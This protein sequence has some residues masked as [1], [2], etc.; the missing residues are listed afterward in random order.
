MITGMV[1]YSGLAIRDV[2][3]N[4]PNDMVNANVPATRVARPIIGRSMNRRTSP[5]E[6]P[7]IDAAWRYRGRIL[8]NA[9][10]RVRTTNG[11]ATSV[12][13]NGINIH[14]ARKSS[15]GS[16]RATIKPKPRVTALVPRGNIKRE[17][18]PRLMGE[19]TWRDN[20]IA[21]GKP[22]V[23]ANTVVARA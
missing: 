1:G 22:I 11:K 12:W 8:R 3:P 10:V 23:N 5:G 4:S 21:A 15:G 2:A 18:R 13:A 7:N 17:S 6:A 14:E 19:S 16:S 20:A 9:G